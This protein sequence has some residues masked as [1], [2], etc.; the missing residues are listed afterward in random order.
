[1]FQWWLEVVVLWRAG[2]L[3]LTRCARVRRPSSGRRYSFSCPSPNSISFSV[4]ARFWI[5]HCEVERTGVSSK[6]RMVGPGFCA[7][8]SIW[9]YQM[10]SSI[11]TSFSEV[12][13]NPNL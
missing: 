5:W 1:M 6:A 12:D 11:S 7:V 13:L 10:I 9:L 2:A 8:H 4:G 3:D